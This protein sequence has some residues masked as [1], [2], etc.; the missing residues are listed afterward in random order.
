MAAASQAPAAAAAESHKNNPGILDDDKAAETKLEPSSS[1]SSSGSEDH[2]DAAAKPKGRQTTSKWYRKLNPLR[3]Q[4][5]PPV[6]KE[7]TVSR[8]YGANFFSII[9]FQ[10]MAPLMHV[11]SPVKYNGEEGED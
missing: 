10:W 11:S 7:R 5:I 2:H 4:K 3:L 6:P 1:V 8:E 9:T